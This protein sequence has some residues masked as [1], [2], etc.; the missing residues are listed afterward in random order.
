MSSTLNMLSNLAAS[1]TSWRNNLRPASFRGVPFWIDEATESG[2]RRVVA[3][4]YPN[5]DLPT[6]EDLGRA[7]TK[8]HVR[9]YVIGDDYLAQSQALIKACQDYNTPAVF[10][11]PWRGPVSC[12]AGIISWTET[13]DKGGYCAIDIEFHADPA[14][15]GGPVASVST[16]STLLA[17][18]GSALTVGLAAY[19]TVSLMIQYPALLLPMAAGLLGSAAGSLLGLPAATIGGLGTAIAAIALAPG[20]D[21]ATATAVQTVFQSAAVAAIAAATP[22]TPTDDPVLGESPLLAPAADP[23]GGLAALA[24]WGASLPVPANPVLAAQQAAMVALVQGSA[25]LAVLTVYASIDW[26]S[27]NAAATARDQVQTMLD[28][29]LDSASDLDQDDLY[30]AWQVIASQAMLDLIARA[31]ALPSVETWTMQASLPSLV[32]AYDW[33][34]DADRADEIAVMNDV[35]DP[36]FMGFGGVRLSA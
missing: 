8:S 20:D 28:A 4:E 12:R 11:H 3:Y 6:L 14:G 7:A 16:A 22:A 25:V 31:Q 30:R 26:P 36:M 1:L 9:A 10:M 17:G 35:P 18:I 33:F 19:Q 34:Q 29:Q 24:T 23:S 21:A 27:S 5:R 2:G 15:A 32:L 13:K